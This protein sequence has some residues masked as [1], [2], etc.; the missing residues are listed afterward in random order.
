MTQ[1]G[2]ASRSPTTSLPGSPVIGEGQEKGKDYMQ[3]TIETTDAPGTGTSTP[4]NGEKSRANSRPTSMIQLQHD[5]QTTPPELQPIFTYLNAHSNKLY[6]EGYFLKL[7]DL[8]SRASST[9]CRS[10][11][12]LTPCRR[13]S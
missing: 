13:P 11:S 7:H 2:G 3:H 1:W 5:S 10:S 12:K 4:A 9:A 8:D 6:Q